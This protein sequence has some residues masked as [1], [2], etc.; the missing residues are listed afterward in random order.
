MTLAW[1]D[2]EKSFLQSFYSIVSPSLTSWENVDWDNMYDVCQ[3]EGVRCNYLMHVTALDLPAR[4]LSGDLG[5][6]NF[7]MLRH[8]EEM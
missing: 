2:D 1:Y 4:S 8:L 6:L 7:T 5:S 3:L